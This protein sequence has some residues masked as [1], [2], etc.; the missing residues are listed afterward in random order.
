M[1][2]ELLLNKTSKVSDV[3]DD[4]VL[5]G[6]AFGAAKVGQKAIKDIAI[7]ESQIFPETAKGEYLDRAA[8]LF[9][10]SERRG[11]VGSSTYV[12][13]IANSGTIYL[14]TTHVFVATNGIRF[15]VEHDLTVD[16]SGFGYIKVRSI[17]SGVKTNVESNVIT[18][19]T[20]IPVG[21]KKCANEYMATGGA[22]AETDEVFRLRI[23]NNANILSL[24]TLEYYNQ[25]FQNIDDRILKTLNLGKNDDGKQ[26][27]AIVTQNGVDL[28]QGELDSLLEAAKDYFPLSDLNQFGN[29]SGVILQN[30]VWYEIGGATGID[31][32]LQINDLYDPDDVR[33]SIQVN[34]SKKIDFR[35]WVAGDRVEW[36]DLLDIV[37][38]TNGVKYVPDEYFY[39]Q[40]DEQVPANNLPR[41]KNFVMR[42]LDGNII[43]DSNGVLSP[44]FYPT[45]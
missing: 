27:L 19:V 20:P 34:I 7:V 14:A 44:I 12:R 41:V 22:D 18:A 33:Q 1:F 38:K 40:E 35:F 36:D 26:V 2:V 28:T 45:E 29:V 32:R 11:A 25:I 5:N 23:V 6:I 16:A 30:V 37:K 21:H 43:F 8:D 13:V 24:T 3:S 9:G 4:S 31:F 15:E 42:D 10:V 39:P 17:D